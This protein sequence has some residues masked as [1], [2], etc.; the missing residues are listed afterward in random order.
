M[1]WTT[2][3]PYSVLERLSQQKSLRGMNRQFCL[4]HRSLAIFIDGSKLD[5]EVGCGRLAIELSERFLNQ[6]EETT[7]TEAAS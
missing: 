1:M 4:D 3:P 2:L 7:I 5:D 6:A